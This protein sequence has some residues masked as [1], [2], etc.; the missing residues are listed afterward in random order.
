MRRFDPST[1]QPSDPTL[2]LW[3]R[4]KRAASVRE[5]LAL[6][7]KRPTV[8]YESPRRIR[9]LLEALDGEDGGSSS[10][11]ILVAREL[12]KMHED[13]W[14]GPL[15]EAVQWIDGGGAGASAPGETP[16]GEFTLVL[17]AKPEES[18][19]GADADEKARALLAEYRASGLS[20]SA[21]AKAVAND[22][23]LRKS[24]VYALSIG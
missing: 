7:E 2:V 9:A 16:R 4:S 3:S 18:T 23:G 12:T 19:S 5:A 17:D 15:G 8:L 10:R 21:A 1:L 22:L 11:P 14:R 20:P 13:L 24:D 6:A